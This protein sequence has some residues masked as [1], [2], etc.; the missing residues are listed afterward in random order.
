MT[1]QI[2]VYSLAGAWGIASASPFCLK[3]LTWLRMA[4][5]D[6]RVTYLS[7]PPKSDTGKAPYIDR[8]DGGYLADS[9][10]IIDT[11]SEE[12]GVDLDEHL[13]DEQRT[14]ARLLTRTLEEG[15]YFVLLWQRW[16]ENWQV[17]R[18][19]FFGEM[20][21]MLRAVATPFIRK[22]V[23]KQARAQGIG[24]CQKE[25][26]FEVGCADIDTV[27]DVLGDNDFFFDEPSTTDAIAHAFLANLL[28]A[29]IDDPL[30][31][32]VE[33]HDNLAHFCERMDERYWD[34]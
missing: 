19:A 10:V 14:T 25:R 8:P 1:Q 28:A 30:R 7:G 18:E 12:R 27:A 33:H 3:L 23:V 21:A 9:S 29:P 34:D 2:N 6:H 4:D 26:I 16:D 32:R 24:R 5:I 20:P 11:L 13:T 17:T 22:N 15:F 31:R